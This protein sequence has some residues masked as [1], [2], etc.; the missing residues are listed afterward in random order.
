MVPAE[1][2]EFSATES[3]PGQERSRKRPAWAAAY[4]KVLGWRMMVQ[5]LETMETG[6]EKETKRMSGWGTILE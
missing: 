6:I 4:A 5:T 1:A 3:D 2:L